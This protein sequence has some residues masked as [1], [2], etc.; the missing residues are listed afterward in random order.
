MKTVL[1]TGSA[2]LVGT[3]FK[4]LAPKV[5]GYNWAFSTRELCDLTKYEQVYRMFNM[6]E[7]HIV[8]H[9][10]GYVGGVNL[11]Q[12][13]PARVM[14]ENIEINTNVID[15]CIQF[16]VEKL[17]AFSSICAMPDNWGTLSEDDMH[18]GPPSSYNEGYA[19]AK[20]LIDVYIRAWT[21]QTDSVATKG[22]CTIIPVNIA[23]IE[24]NYNIKHGHVI[25]SLAHKFW[26]AINKGEPLQV[27]GDGSPQREFIDSD[28]LAQM[29]IQLLDKKEL[30]PR[31][32]LSSGVEHSI[33][34][35]VT[36][37]C[38]ITGYKGPIEWGHGINGQARRPTNTDL[39]RS[40]GLSPSTP[41]RTTLEKS[42]R[43]FNQNYEKARK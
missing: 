11:H 25:P 9:T 35:I 36:I 12:D 18:Q 2:G 16:G 29:C 19:F 40:L 21:K 39:M 28:D 5:E 20:R 6:V 34:D 4:R 13:E 22:Y 3:A 42:W 1:V 37:L 27:F 43:W 10:A 33:K 38:E 30:P 8:I 7:P 32:I 17:L 31:L 26:R 15:S 23:G 41:L 14:S 24:D